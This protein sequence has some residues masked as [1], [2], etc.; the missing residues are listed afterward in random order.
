MQ[1]GIAAHSKSHSTGV[2][3]LNRILEPRQTPSFGVLE[4]I[5]LAVYVALLAWGVAHH[6][7]WADEAQAWQ[8][9]RELPLPTLFKTYLHY[10]GSPGLWYV[11]LWILVRLHVTFAG[12]HWI[13]AVLPISGMWVFLRYS[14]F[15]AIV[16]AVVPFSFYLM[17]QYAVVARSYLAFALLVFIAAILFAKPARNLLWLT[18]VF[19]L[20]SNLTAHGFAVTAGFA[21]MLAVRLW[22]QRKQDAQFLTV[23]R[24]AGASVCLCASMVFAA[25]AARNVPDNSFIPGYE[26]TAQQGSMDS[27][28]GVSDGVA[29]AATAPDANPSPPRQPAPGRADRLKMVVTYGLSNS[30]AISL[31]VAIV[32]L[33]Y[34]ISVRNVLDLLPFVFLHLLYHFVKGNSWHFGIVFIALLGVLWINWPLSGER[35]AMTWRGILSA[36]LLAIAVEQCFW[37]VR[38]F[39]IDTF[40]KYSGDRDAAE[41]LLSHIAGKR[42]AGF[43]YQCVGV[44]PYFSTNIF[45]NQPPGAFWHWSKNA[46]IDD[47][48]VETAQSRPDYIDVGFAV[49]PLDFVHSTPL[50]IARIKTYRPDEEKQ[51]LATGLYQETHRFCGLAFSGHGYAEGEC[52]VILEPVRR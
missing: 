23:G 27:I 29:P 19:V 30:W 52:Q 47:R 46:H 3:L 7:S 24:L 6:I 39:R 50:D 51:I 10:E 26:R 13:A 48:T 22:R 14:P 43:K 1:T 2:S 44:L 18:L 49:R 20:L 15:P 34:L 37:T 45:E 8:L 17:Y 31:I 38:A 42:V 36:T 4:G 21:I 33:S 25:W 12:M 35:R 5:V 11:F 32:V 40:G 41:F 16:R 28:Q 9:A